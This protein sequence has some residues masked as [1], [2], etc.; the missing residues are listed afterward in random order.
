MLVDTVA[1]IKAVRA[2]LLEEHRARVCL[3]ELKTE[4]YRPRHVPVKFLLPIVAAYLSERGKV[5]VVEWNNIIVFSDISAA[6]HVV[7]QLLANLDVGKS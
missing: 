7:K 6:R 1:A 4:F 2:R 5:H 3:E